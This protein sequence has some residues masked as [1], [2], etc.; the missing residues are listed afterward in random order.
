MERAGRL[1][2]QKQT[3]FVG[4]R[5][6]LESVLGELLPLMQVLASYPPSD[7]AEAQLKIRVHHDGRHKTA[8]HIRSSKTVHLCSL[9][10]C[11]CAC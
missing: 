11:D 10:I 8:L 1:Q 7:F 4:K 3:V 9:W 6:F 2:A 5:K